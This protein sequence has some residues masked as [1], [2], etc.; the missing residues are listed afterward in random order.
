MRKKGKLV[1]IIA[2]L[3]TLAGLIA[4]T[5]VDE[6]EI[7]R[8]NPKQA[9]DYRLPWRN[10]S[11]TYVDGTALGVTVGS[12]K[13]EAIEAAERAGLTVGPSGWGDNRAGGASLYDRPTLVATMLR[14]RY[15]NFHDK[16]D[17]RRGMTIHFRGDLVQ[18][19]DVYYINTE[20]I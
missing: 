5:A 8:E 20:A 13:I 6:R 11:E 12:T 19:I 7:G 1:A 10:F 14:Q 15:L 9:A 4:F 2:M 17:T 18:S 3:A 16:A